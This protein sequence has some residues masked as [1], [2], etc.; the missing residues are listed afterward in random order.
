MQL[1]E[2]RQNCV[3]QNSF[4]WFHVAESLVI[5]AA[6]WLESPFGSRILGGFAG[7]LTEIIWLRN[8]RTCLRGSALSWPGRVLAATSGRRQDSPNRN[9]QFSGR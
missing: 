6:C 5:S 9:L 7:C 3:V 8:Q 1:T 2:N 4:S